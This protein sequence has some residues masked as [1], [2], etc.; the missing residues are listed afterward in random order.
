[1]IRRS[2]ALLAAFILIIGL[3]C[4]TTG[5]KPKPGTG[6]TSSAKVIEK[7]AHPAIPEGVRCYVCHKRDIPD[8]AFHEKY[9]TNCEECHIKSTW[10]AT[11][12]SHPGWLRTGAHLARCTRCHTKMAEY[13]FS[14]QCWGCH[15]DKALTEKSHA[16]KGLTD[17]A[18]CVACHKDVKL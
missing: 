4:A 17:I 6:G 1:M 3:G 10:M 9:G 14:Y 2:I 12:Y 15:H 8:H 16:D 13:D 18:N 5:P 11:K 7:S